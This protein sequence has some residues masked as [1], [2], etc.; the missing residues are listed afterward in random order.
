M[1]KHF[2]AEVYFEFCCD[3]WII[4]FVM[5]LKN[6]LIKIIPK[7]NLETKDRKKISRFKTK[8]K[9]LV[10]WLSLHITKMMYWYFIW[11]DSFFSFLLLIGIQVVNDG[12]MMAFSVGKVLQ[13]I[14]I[15]AVK[16]H[17]SNVKIG[18]DFKNDVLIAIAK[19]GTKRIG[20]IGRTGTVQNHWFLI[21][22]QFFA[23]LIP[24]RKGRDCDGRGGA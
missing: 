4:F 20:C 18:H 21:R 11:K 24:T 7:N 23:D 14:W 13:T 16:C 6:R 5:C 3:F 17:T 22:F 10:W 19:G 8:R 2:A 9:K 12:V 1:S 15:L